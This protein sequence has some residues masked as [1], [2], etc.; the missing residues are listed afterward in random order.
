MKLTQRTDYALRVMM[1][2]ALDE[3]TRTA[4]EMA[5]TLGVSEHHLAK[6]AKDLRARGY[7]DTRRGRGGGFRLARAPEAIRVGEV[8][9]ELEELG[10][11]ECFDARVNRCVMTGA[12]GLQGALTQARG[13]FLT[14]LDEHTLA[15]LVARRGP[16]TR[17]LG[18]IRREAR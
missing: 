1:L 7:L 12:C 10:L 4:S 14:A 15:S 9:R 17:R 18:L 11:V 8:V 2:L 16:L 3:D 6:V 5:A 13:A